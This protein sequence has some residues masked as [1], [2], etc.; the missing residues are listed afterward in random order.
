MTARL[1]SVV[2][3]AMLVVAVTGCQQNPFRSSPTTVPVSFAPQ[4]GSPASTTLA[5]APAPAS[6]FPSFANTDPKQLESQLARSRQE[7]QVAQDE[8]AALREQLAATST[9]LAQA[10]SVARPEAPPGGD[11]GAG[12][13]SGSTPTVASIG[14]AAMQEGMTHLAIPGA[15]ARLDGGVV[16]IEIPADKLF[17]PGT[18][19]LLPAGASLLSQAA[20]EVQRVYPGQFV[21][22]EG[23]TDTEP[24][25]NANWGSPH[26]LS[27]ARSSAVF[28]FFTSRTT[29]K[30]GQL[31]LVAHGPNHPVVSNAT[32]AGRARNRRIELVIYPEQAA[33][34]PAGT[35]PVD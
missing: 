17:E 7:T 28:E 18:A 26:Q 2:A 24:L 34:E 3:A 16:R 4:S 1:P 30:Q 32:A 22:V 10:R 20:S 6:Q 25:Q 27:V 35:A 23:H 33:A 5:L 14:Q 31:F 11:W 21:G 29:L 9:Q 19:S 13:Q 8:L 12:G 15:T